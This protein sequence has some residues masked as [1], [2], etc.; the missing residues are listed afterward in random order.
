MALHCLQDLSIQDFSYLQ[1]ISPG[2]H[3]STSG[4]YD[5]HASHA[6][7]ESDEKV[8][9]AAALAKDLQE[10]NKRL[11]DH[12]HDLETRKRAPL[13]QK[14]QEEELKAA[15]EKAQEADSRAAE[16]EAKCKEAKVCEND[17]NRKRCL[18]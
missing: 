11:E 10:A 9:E 8:A 4:Y 2:W 14:K 15:V 6:L 13:Y 12:I 1:L 3:H 16:A 17:S 7:Q 5:K 18:A